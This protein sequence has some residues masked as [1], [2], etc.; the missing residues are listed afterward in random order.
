MSNAQFLKK[1]YRL[2]ECIFFSNCFY[3][4]CAVALS[5][6]ATLQQGFTLNGLA[7]YLITFFATV[8]YY[9]Y[10]YVRKCPLITTNKRTNW[11]TRNYAW[12]CFSQLA[13]SVIL[14]VS[15]GLFLWI[16]P[17]EVSA[18]AIVEWSLIL[19]FPF[20]AALYYGINIIPGK[21]NIR[22]IGWLK[23][24][25]IGFIWAG[26]VTI[27]PVL[28]HNIIHRQN[29]QFTRVG[30]LLFVKN[31]MFITVSCIMFDIKDYATD[32]IN[33][34]RTFVVKLGL[35]KTVYRILVPLSLFGLFSF[36]CYALFHHFHP[37]RLIF[38]VIPFILLIVAAI[39]LCRRRP[40]MYYL[41]IVDG[42]MLVKALCGSVAI[43]YF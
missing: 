10:P 37:G 39:S 30:L 22:K 12:V 24:F 16:Y 38:N 31:F 34:L 41:V 3:G 11:Y 42:L 1:G 25:V 29:Y 43:L 6:E 19:V 26:M 33:R 8:L 4:L 7:Y 21:C 5:V 18:M 20:T 17:A 13:I 9:T 35:R 15:F 23:P 14:L 40:L 36:I 2:L 28:F 32:Y 27:Y